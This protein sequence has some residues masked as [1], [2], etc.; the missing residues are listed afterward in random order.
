MISNDDTAIEQIREVRHRISTENGHDPRKIVES[1]I[2][3]QKE[4]DNR[5]LDLGENHEEH[6]ETVKTK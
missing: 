5:L 4:Y 1:Y 3:F 2:K 6:L